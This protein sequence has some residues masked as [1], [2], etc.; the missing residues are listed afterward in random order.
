MLCL[1]RL[2]IYA[3]S[4]V[5]LMTRIAEAWH[6][7]AVLHFCQNTK[8]WVS[9]CH[10]TSFAPIWRAYALAAPLPWTLKLKLAFSGP[11][12]LLRYLQPSVHRRAVEI[13]A[14]LRLSMA[15]SQ[16]PEA[17]LDEGAAMRE[18]AAEA[19]PVTS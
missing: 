14:R 18:R 2:R 5:Q 4:G 10:E 11:R 8:P 6:D 9:N 12:Q 1:S 15:S 17:G 16:A 3:W 7:P 13:R 19:R